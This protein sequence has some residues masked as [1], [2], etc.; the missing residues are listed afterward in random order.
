MAMVRDSEHAFSLTEIIIVIIVI[1]ILALI[2]IPTYQHHL[3]KTHRA[4]GQLALL[5]L[6]SLL[7]NYYLRE[8][9]YNGAT[10]TRL[11]Q[12]LKSPEGYYQLNIVLE[13]DGQRY[14][15]QA[16]PLGAQA[17]N[18]KACGTLQLST[19]GGRTYLGNDPDAS[20]W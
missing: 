7:E 18:D 16:I 12:P 14:Q 11:G 6:S 19:D 3:I 9:T 15:A 17:A 13:N 10:L 20:C 2:A 8:H 1:A 4:D 5:K